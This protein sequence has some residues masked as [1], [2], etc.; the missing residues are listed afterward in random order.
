VRR[1][2]ADEG[3]HHEHA[4]AI[5]H[6][7]RQL[8]PLRPTADDAQPVAQPLHGRAAHEDAA[9]E[10]VVGRAIDAPAHRGQQA[11]VRGHRMAAQ[12]H[13]HEAARAVGILDHARLMAG[14]AEGRGLLVAGDA[15]HRDRRAEQAAWVVPTSSLDDTTCGSTASGMPNRCSRS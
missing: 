1:A 3:R 8:L 10:Q 9:F 4:A 15:G 6:A 7:G 14:L 5:R 13:Q 2:E 11:V 12:M